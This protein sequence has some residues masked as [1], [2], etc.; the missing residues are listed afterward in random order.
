MQI[1]AAVRYSFCS[2]P[3]RTI[4]KAE[5]LFKRYGDFTAVA[6]VDFEIFQGECFGF[7]GP[8]GAGKTSTMKA[9]SCVSP[10]S[11]GSVSVSGMDV[12][13]QARDIKAALGVVSQADSLDPDL[14]VFQ[15]L[16]AFARY[17]DLPQETARRRAR[18]GLELFQLL[19]KRSNR[20]EELSGGM[21]RRLLIA[22]AL[23]NDPEILVLD[24]PTT[25]LD[26]QARLL[27]W[28][29]LSLL[30][31][32]G[33][34]MLLTTH[35]MDEAAYLCDRLVVMDGG[36]ILA[37]GAPADLIRETVGSHVVEIRVRH[38]EKPALMARLQAARAVG[39]VEDRADTILLYP[40]NGAASPADFGLDDEL[41]MTRRPA[42]LE[43]VFLRLTGRGLR[44]E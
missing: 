13:R 20:V 4:I 44:E 35:Y 9:L 11:G 3:R 19:D 34:T 5:R 1:P 27:V 31:S 10:L 26:P 22:R 28:D 15:N 18:E 36:K 14:D 17:F 40:E 12:E 38:A 30:K 33:I 24:E 8:N 29:K 43:D 42:N 23:I 2:M 25:G 21:R 37:R 7:L 39:R 32:Q 6:G 41:D 16:M